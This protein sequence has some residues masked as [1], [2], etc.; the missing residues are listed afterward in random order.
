[1]RFKNRYSARRISSCVEEIRRLITLD[2]AYGGVWGNND[3][4]KKK[5]RIWLTNVEYQCICID[6][7]ILKDKK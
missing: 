3:D 2:T 6:K 7:E 5:L 4:I 1:M